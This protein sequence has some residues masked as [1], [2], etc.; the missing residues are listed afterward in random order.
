MKSASALVLASPDLNRP[1]EV[2]CDA[3]GVGLGAVLVQDGKPF[4][5][6]EKQTV[7]AEMNY[8]ASEQY[9]LAIVCA[10]EL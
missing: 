10:L 1:F 6:E 5:F 9:L 3:C 2:I 4:A 7:P 8:H